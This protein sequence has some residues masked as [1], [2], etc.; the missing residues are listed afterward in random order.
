MSLP[1][2]KHRKLLSKIYIYNAIDW[3]FATYHTL[4]F[5]IRHVE[6]LEYCFLLNIICCRA[7]MEEEISSILNIC[8]INEKLVE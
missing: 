6:N 5:S 2:V 1:S 7:P 3:N 4:K 8:Y